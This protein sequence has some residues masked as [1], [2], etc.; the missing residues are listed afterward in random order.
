MRKRLL[1]MILSA[2]LAMSMFGCGAKDQGK[3]TKNSDGEIKI[4][5]PT[6]MAGENVGAVFFVP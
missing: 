1:A 2:T 4:T 6:Y 3:T 5:F